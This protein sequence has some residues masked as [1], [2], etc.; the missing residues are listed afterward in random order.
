MLR[1]V[2]GVTDRVSLEMMRVGIKFD[3]KPRKCD[4]EEPPC[5]GERSGLRKVIVG[6]DSAKSVQLFRSAKLFQS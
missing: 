5:V 4:L 3:A 2:Y 1:R 6:Y